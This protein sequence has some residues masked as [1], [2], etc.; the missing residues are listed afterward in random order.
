MCIS[1]IYRTA[2]AR[3]PV[4]KKGLIKRNYIKEQVGLQVNLNIINN[5]PVLKNVELFESLQ[6][7]KEFILCL[8]HAIRLGKEPHETLSWQ[9]IKSERG[10]IPAQHMTM[11]THMFA[12]PRMRVDLWACLSLA[13]YTAAR[14]SDYIESSARGGSEDTT[15]ILFQ[16]EHGESEFV[17]YKLDYRGAEGLSQLLNLR[18]PPG[19]SQI[20]IHWHRSVLG[21]P[22]FSGP[23][24]KMLRANAFG[25]ELRSAEI[26]AGFPDPPSL[27]C[28]RAEGLTNVGIR[29][30]AVLTSPDSNPMYS[31]TQR[32][33]LAGHENNQIH[34]QYYS[35]RNPGID[36][37]AAY[38]GVQARGVNIGELFR[39]LEVPWEPAL[40]QSLPA[41]K[42]QELRQTKE[43]QAIVAQILALS[44]ARRSRKA[45]KGLGISRLD[46]EEEG[47]KRNL[48]SNKPDSILA[49][50]DR[51]L[52]RDLKAIEQKALRKFWEEMSTQVQVGSR[53]YTCRGVNHP[54]SR[55]RPILPSR[56]QLAGLLL[57][58]TSIRSP[59]GRA[60]LNA[61]IDLYNSKTEVD[62]RG[63]NP[64]HCSCRVSNPWHSRGSK[65]PSYQD[66]VSFA[67]GTRT[68]PRRAAFI[69]SAPRTAGR[70]TS[71]L[72]A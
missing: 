30:V 53:A 56:R 18:V 37:Q 65:A 21:Q 7:L 12:R 9:R 28:Y 13:A 47:E 62:R 38:L 57:T 69:N 22:I 64:S 16:N 71:G 32:Q 50:P 27:H 17:L 8:R 23:S 25:K 20:L 10:K 29:G 51:K 35:S 26:R 54:F 33:R 6:D 55:L 48:S 70:I 36:S 34:Q 4:L 41:A 52:N 58:N 63:L 49:H 5:K 43:Y 19:Q 24:G 44:A 68:L 40:W 2:L 60:A 31:D 66:T 11:I 67:Y 39:N 59:A 61:L 1:R 3:S 46:L 14:I 72:T 15:L 45:E 42:H